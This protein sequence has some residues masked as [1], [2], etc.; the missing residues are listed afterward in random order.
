[1]E[2]LDNSSQNSEN[3]R[4]A[5]LKRST[6]WVGTGAK[7]SFDGVNTWVKEPE[8]TKKSRGRLGWLG[9]GILL[10]I[11]YITSKPLQ[12]LL[13]VPIGAL[14]LFTVMALYGDIL[15]KKKP[16]EP[17]KT[18]PNPKPSPLEYDLPPLDLEPPRVDLEKHIPEPTREAAEELIRETPEESIR[19]ALEEVTEVP[20]GVVEELKETSLETTWQTPGA[21]ED[22]TPVESPVTPT[23]DPLGSAPTLPLEDTPTMRLTPVTTAP[24]R[25]VVSLE[26][27]EQPQ[28]WPEAQ[29][30]LGGRIV[31][32]GERQ[33]ASTEEGR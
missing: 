30:P 18:D 2:T 31:L 33:W 29:A 15:L 6:T 19:E 1:M 5:T 24:E 23:A 17:E 16:E 3:N 32:A 26:K 4:S 27:A 21:I 20:E 11:A 7:R 22:V 8:D 25:P 14:T 13:V 9:F 10:L 28:L 12:A